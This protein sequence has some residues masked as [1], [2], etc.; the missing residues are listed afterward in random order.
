[1]HLA[2]LLGEPYFH[3]P[4]D[5]DINAALETACRLCPP[6]VAAAL[7]QI[8]QVETI[9][10]ENFLYSTSPVDAAILQ[11]DLDREI[12]RNQEATEYRDEL[13][14]QL[15]QAGLDSANLPLINIPSFRPLTENPPPD[16]LELITINI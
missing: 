16:V 4:D 5:R 3:Y 2:N 6:V 8:R 12:P 9:H 15:M 11:Q 13:V 10:Y 14:A 7:N 1:M